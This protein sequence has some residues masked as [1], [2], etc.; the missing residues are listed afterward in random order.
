MVT[1]KVSFKKF[2]EIFICL[3]K[4]VNGYYIQ[5][6]FKFEIYN[7]TLCTIFFYDNNYDNLIKIIHNT[8]NKKY[9]CFKH[10]YI[11]HVS[12]NIQEF[13]DFLKLEFQKFYL[14]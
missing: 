2:F 10:W 14:N 12:F 13:P 11:I 4:I 1:M 7:K 3:L 9:A 6:L 8:C 5:I